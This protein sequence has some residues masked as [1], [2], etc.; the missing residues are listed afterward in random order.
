MLLAAWAFWNGCGGVTLAAVLERLDHD[1][2][3]GLCFLAL[4]AKCGSDAIDDWIAK[5]AVRV[6]GVPKN[7]RT[8]MTSVPITIGALPTR[9]R[10]PLDGTYVEESDA[11][12]R[13]YPTSDER[14]LEPPGSDP[15]FRAGGYLRI[16][17]FPGILRNFMATSTAA[18]P[19]A[20]QRAAR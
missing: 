9:E 5:P 12:P 1:P 4:A 19:C 10:L 17:V 16:G 3:E 6:T 15:A 11:L 13:R 20:A 14:L 7:V 8:R 2:A 18:A